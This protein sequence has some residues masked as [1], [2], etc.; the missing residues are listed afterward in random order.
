[1]HRVNRPEFACCLPPLQNFSD[2][3]KQWPEI[4]LHDPLKVVCPAPARPHHLA[5][6]N[7][8]VLR[9]HPNCAP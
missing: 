5:L 6:H 7:S 1:M 9:I 3:A 2:P 4:F 8:R